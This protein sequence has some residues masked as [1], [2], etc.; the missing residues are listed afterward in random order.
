MVQDYS[1]GAGNSNRAGGEHGK[2]WTW[3]W[4]ILE[5]VIKVYSCIR[6]LIRMLGRLI[7]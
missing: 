5:I 2:A 1:G 4:R 3:T 7:R 6:T